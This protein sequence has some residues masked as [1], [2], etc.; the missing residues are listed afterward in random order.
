MYKI[1]SV[2]FQWRGILP[3]RKLNNGLPSQGS[4][5]IFIHGVASKGTLFTPMA[6][7]SIVGL[8]H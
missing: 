4:N 7:K 8:V 6:K 2:P 1:W 5:A 3:A